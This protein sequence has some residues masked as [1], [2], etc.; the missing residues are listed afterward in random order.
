MTHIRDIPM[1]SH[2]VFKN[3]GMEIRHSDN[4]QVVNQGAKSKGFPPF[5]N[6]NGLIKQCHGVGK[7]KLSELVDL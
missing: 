2:H 5:L 4:K 6:R 1:N 7:N 3:I